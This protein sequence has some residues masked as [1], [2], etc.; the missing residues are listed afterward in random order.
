MPRV[1]LVLLLSFVMSTVSRGDGTVSF[2][3][4]A[5]RFDIDFVTIGNPGNAPDTT[6]DPSPAGAVPY[7]YNIGKYEISREMVAKTNADG[8]LGI[9]LDNMSTVTG[10]T[11]PSMPATGVSWNEAARFV[12]WLN[13]S[14]GYSPAYKFTTQPGEPGYDA[15]A[16]LLLWDSA[17]AGFDAANPYRNRLARYFLPSV[18][19]WYKA[20]YFDP[21]AES[22]V[23]GYWNFAAGSDRAPI[24]VSSG[25]RTGTA[26]YLRPSSSGPADVT[27]AGGLSPYGVVGLGGNAWEWEETEAD[28]INNGRFAV[29]GLRGGAW[30]NNAFSLGASG[31]FADFPTLENFS[32]G[33][34]VA[35]IPEPSA[36]LF[37][38]LWL[39][40]M[41]RKTQATD[42]VR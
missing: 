3:T 29:R 26:V 27:Q 25:T 32:I 7:V 38:V 12:N 5:N 24:P 2:G 4:G 16:D 41:A 20:A 37:G 31:R 33:F 22:G 36:G 14:Q 8:N 10:G 9:T 17:D 23:G 6:G 1:T 39:L 18:N 30:Y 19:E 28:L 15:K 35:S 11:R 13:T 40:A 42:C 21:S 34:R